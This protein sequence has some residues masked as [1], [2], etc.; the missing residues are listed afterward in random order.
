MHNLC[1]VSEKYTSIIFD[2]QVK[3]QLDFLYLTGEQYVS[4][5]SVI[6]M[7]ETLIFH[8]LR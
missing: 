5:T 3:I 4:I 6:H 2:R 7:D 1:Q 8:Y